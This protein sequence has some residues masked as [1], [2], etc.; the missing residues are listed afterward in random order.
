MLKKEFHETICKVTFMLP[1]S[2]L[3][4]GFENAEKAYLAGEFNDWNEESHPMQKTP[5]GFSLTVDLDLNQEYQFRYLVDGS[6]WYNDW[7]ADKYVPNPFIGD[8][9]IVT[10]YVGENGKG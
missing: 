3:P 9:S 6:N 2:E 10:T 7:H 4:E 8:N 1:A 5:Q